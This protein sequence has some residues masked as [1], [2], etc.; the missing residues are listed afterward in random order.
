MD[1]YRLSLQHALAFRHRDS[2]LDISPDTML[3]AGKAAES[4][5]NPGLMGVKETG[6]IPRSLLSVLVQNG[7]VWHTIDRMSDRGRAVDPSL[8]NP[9]TGRA[10]T[11][12]SSG[13]AL[14]VL[15]GIN[16]IG[17]CSDGGGSVLGPALSLSLYSIMAKGMGLLCSNNRISTD[18]IGFIPGVGAVSHSLSN[19]VRFAECFAVEDSDSRGLGG[20]VVLLG[21]NFSGSGVF[22]SVKAVLAE[23]Q[24]GHSEE[25]LPSDMSRAS[26]IDWVAGQFGAGRTILSVE[27][28]A[29]VCGFGDSLCGV[30]GQCG[31]EYYDGHGK[32]LVKV[33]NMCNATALTLPLSELGSG[34]VLMAPEGAGNASGLLELALRLDREN[35]PKLYLDYF[36]DCALKPVNKIAFALE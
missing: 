17:I 9:L 4:G 16:D 36:R 25:V 24:I 19:I 29:D 13:T 20:G 12:S 3:E 1:L 28:P 34:L 11:G 15:Y 21:N 18:G 22:D 26:L 7:F 14:N 5:L 2:V 23:N 35:R 30:M 33:A 27:G 31:N 10:M 32:Y 6:G 8:V